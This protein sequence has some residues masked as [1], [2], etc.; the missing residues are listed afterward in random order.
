MRISFPCICGCSP[1]H[2]QNRCLLMWPHSSYFPHL[3]PDIWYSFIRARPDGNV[4]NEL[5]LCHFSLPK[6]F[7]GSPTPCDGCSNP[8]F[9][10]SMPS[11][12]WTNFSIPA[13]SPC[14]L[15]LSSNLKKASFQNMR[16]K[17]PLPYLCSCYLFIMMSKW[18]PAHPY[19][20]GL[21][22]IS[23]LRPRHKWLLSP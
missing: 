7:N 19:R 11:A 9:E 2:R 20:P 3:S 21:N 23:S 13:N 18:T 15:C 6:A 16:L 22:A 4:S 14:T 8:S 5:W 12:I 10:H 1:A 17:F